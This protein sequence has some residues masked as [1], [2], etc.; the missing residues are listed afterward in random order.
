MFFL[1]ARIKAR[2]RAKQNRFDFCLRT[3]E[4]YEGN[5]VFLTTIVWRIMEIP[6]FQSRISYSMEY[7]RGAR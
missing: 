7:L 2:F 4:Y 3:L 5:S 6:A 1:E